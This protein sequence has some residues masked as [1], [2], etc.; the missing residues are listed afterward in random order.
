LHHRYQQQAPEITSTYSRLLVDSSV[1]ICPDIL[2]IRSQGDYSNRPP[3]GSQG[4]PIRT[5]HGVF[6][7]TGGVRGGQAIVP[8]YLWQFRPSPRH[9]RTCARENF[10]TT[11]LVP[12][13]L[14]LQTHWD[15]QR[16]GI[17]FEVLVPARTERVGPARGRRL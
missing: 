10:C 5:P 15:T 2:G 8:L 6:V 1:C 9:C 17:T 4:A 14:V 11:T 3:H 16:A 12:R 13:Y 7:R